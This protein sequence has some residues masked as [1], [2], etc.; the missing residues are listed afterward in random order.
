M[1][2]AGVEML[3]IIFAAATAVLCGLCL[4]L[5]RQCKVFAQRYGRQNAVIIFRPD[6]KLETITPELPEDIA[7]IPMYVSFTLGLGYLLTMSDFVAAIHY[8]LNKLY[9]GGISDKFAEQV[10][11]Y[12]V[13][14]LT[15]D[16]GENA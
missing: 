9:T 3:T 4:Y 14:D 11:I 8:L 12:K 7:E 2:I 6:G 10:E 13:E 1:R 5:H 15:N 16:E